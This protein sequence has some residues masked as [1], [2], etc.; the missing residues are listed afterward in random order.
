M[1]NELGLTVLDTR[2]NRYLSDTG[3]VV[4]NGM[5]TPGPTA[6]SGVAVTCY[7]YDS[8]RS[9]SFLHTFTHTDKR[10]IIANIQNNVSKKQFEM[11]PLKQ[12][13]HMYNCTCI[14]T[15]VIMP[16]VLFTFYAAYSYYSG[17]INNYHSVRPK[18]F[19]WLKLCSITIQHS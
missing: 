16:M 19:S 9:H 5:E 11:L 4:W 15:S 2:T 6:S 12:Y 3:G 14:P 1:E 17:I 8:S 18:D 13:S 10:P 7:K